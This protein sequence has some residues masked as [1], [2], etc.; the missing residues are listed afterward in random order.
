MTRG[1]PAGRG[2]RA[3][4]RWTAATCLAS[5]GLGLALAVGVAPGLG[6]PPPN[7]AIAAAEPIEGKSGSRRGTNVEATDEPGE[8]AYDDGRRSVWYRWVAPASGQFLFETCNASGVQPTTYDTVLAAFAGAS[9]SEFRRVAQNDDACQEQSQIVFEAAAGTTYHVVVAG[10][11]GE[12]GAFTLRW[13]H[14]V[15]PANDAFAQPQ[16]LTGA[17]GTVTGSNQ[18]ATLEPGE[19]AHADESGASVW[20]VWTAPANLRLTFETC[21]SSFDTLL[22]IYTGTSLSTLTRVVQGDDECRLS[23]RVR[24]DARAGTTYRI[25]LAGYGEQGTFRLAWLR[26]PANDDTANAQVVR[27]PRGTLTGTNVAAT[28]EPNEPSRHRAT[29]WYRWRA[30][31]STTVAFSTCTASFDTVLHVFR[32]TDSGRLVAVGSNDDGCRGEGVGSLLVVHPA[33][34]ATYYVGVDGLSG[35]TG[36]YRL[37]WGRPPPYAWCVVPDVRGMALAQARTRLERANCALGRV[38]RVRSTIAPRGRVVSQFPAPS[39]TRR[40]YGTRVNVEV[41]AGR[42]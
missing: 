19:P 20:Y 15:A 25:A 5:L 28:R 1:A 42:R 3:P 32:T 29:V 10:Y 23:T 34:R 21:G 11:E 7:D 8:P 40:T 41:S 16:T 30:P 31:S 22:V 9:P 6:A 18:G 26:R 17:T 37:Q 33:A 2:R 24:L 35:A 38:V 39:S 4:A 14:L 27:G 13:R 12:T 36:T